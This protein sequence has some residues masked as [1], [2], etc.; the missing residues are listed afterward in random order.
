MT[1]SS[2]HGVWQVARRYSRKTGLLTLLALTLTAGWPGPATAGSAQTTI[3]IKLT[4]LAPPPCEVT[5]ASGGRVEVDFGNNVGI[6]KIDG[7]HYR[8]PM[9]YVIKCQT[10]NVSGL[11]LK[12][13][14]KGTGAGFDTSNAA[15][16]TNTDG[17]GIRIYQNGTPFVLNQPLTITKDAPPLLEA[18]PVKASGVTLK[19]GPF[20][21]TATLLAEYE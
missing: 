19:E 2:A 1:N 21:A 4:V 12:L 16:A 13:T 8:Q 20:E 9:N 3:T 5:S 10:G 17:L 18:V 11:A 6:N 7:T 14:L 15:L